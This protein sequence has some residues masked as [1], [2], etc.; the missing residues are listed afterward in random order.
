MHS[1]AKLIE[2]KRAN[3]RNYA[4]VHRVIESRELRLHLNANTKLRLRLV[5]IF[6]SVRKN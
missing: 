6:F 5:V 2:I 1:Y 4:F 3:V